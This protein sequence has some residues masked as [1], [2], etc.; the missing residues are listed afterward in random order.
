MF[1]S[2]KKIKQV[3]HFNWILYFIKDSFGNALTKKCEI[4]SSECKFCFGP[5]ASDCIAI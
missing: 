4:C 5:A 2:A 3:N 1:L